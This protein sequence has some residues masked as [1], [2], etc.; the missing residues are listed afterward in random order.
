MQCQAD[1]PV[2]YAVEYKYFA[3]SKRTTVLPSKGTKGSWK[4]S[5]RFYVE[6]IGYETSGN[7]EVKTVTFISQEHSSKRTRRLEKTAMDRQNVNT[8]PKPALRVLAPPLT[9][10]FR[11]HS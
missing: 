1:G 6:T 5:V 10:T 7:K 9:A 4:T 11:R 2:M 3:I 8:P